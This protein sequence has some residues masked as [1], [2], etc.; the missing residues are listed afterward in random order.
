MQTV[1]GSNCTPVCP[2]SR[3]CLAGSRLSRILDRDLCL[4]S[5]RFWSSPVM[6]VTDIFLESGRWGELYGHRLFWVFIYIDEDSEKN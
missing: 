4:P 6:I 1:T 2:G 5:I 3:R